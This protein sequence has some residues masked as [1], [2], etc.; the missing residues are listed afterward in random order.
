M[1]T[2]RDSLI[3]KLGTKGASVKNM[4]PDELALAIGMCKE[5]YLSCFWH[6]ETKSTG[7]QFSKLGR[8]TY[9]R[10]LGLQ[11]AGMWKYS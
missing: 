7:Y 11:Q 6:A 8:K 1:I 2:V 10:D 5:G 9:G 3:Q 4:T